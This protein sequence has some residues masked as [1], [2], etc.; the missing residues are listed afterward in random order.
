MSSLSLSMVVFCK[1]SSCKGL[2]TKAFCLLQYLPRTNCGN[3]LKD[4]EEPLLGVL[5]LESAPPLQSNILS[6]KAFGF[7]RL[8]LVCFTET[9]RTS[10]FLGPCVLRKGNLF[11]LRFR[12]RRSL[13]VSCNSCQSYP[14]E[15]NIVSC[16]SGESIGKH[17]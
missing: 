2:S 9:A 1:T 13:N 12:K 8:D 14:F 6:T 4:P 7:S 11:P 15:C 16:V 5:T 10:L 17:N 3:G